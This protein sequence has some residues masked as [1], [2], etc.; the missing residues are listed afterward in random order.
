MSTRSEQFLEAAQSIGMRLCRD[1]IWAG[2]RCNWIGSSME[3]V[4]NNWQTV[5]KAFGSELYAGTAGIG[6]FLAELEAVAHEPIFRK[7]AQAAFS[8]AL[9]RAFELPVEMGIGFYSGI[10]GVGYALIRAGELL[11]HPDYN[12]SGLGM[13]ERLREDSLD[14]QGLDV[15]SGFAGAIPAFLAVG[16]KYHRDDFV[17]L[18]VRCGDRLIA[19]AHPAEAGWSWDTLAPANPPGQKHLCGFSHGTGGIGWAFLEL[20]RVTSERRFRDAADRAF[21]YERHWYSTAYEN[22][23]DFRSATPGQPNATPSYA[24]AWCHGAPGIGLSRVRAY[25]LTGE[26]SFREEAEAALR[27]TERGLQAALTTNQG[28]YSLCHGNF[29]NAELCLQATRVFGKPEHRALAEDLALHAI[30]IHGPRL[31]PWPCGVL[32][33]GE[34]PNLMLGTAGIGHF[35]LRLHD[36]DRTPAVMI[37]LPE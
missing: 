13:F 26:A 27:T 2:D 35:L 21:A 12:A 20:E 24:A 30:G 3:Y 33:A 9:S 6:L 10:T 7:T 31:A 37:I 22:W 16:H 15:V 25:E 28:N 14:R 11:D 18:A 17:E 36:Q 5:Q 29:G 4:A 32:N 23:P 34:T 1:A 19:A 8:T